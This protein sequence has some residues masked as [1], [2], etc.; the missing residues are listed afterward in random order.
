M[1]LI[2]AE[3]GRMK[4]VDLRGGKREGAGRKSTG[5]TKKVSLTLSDELWNEINEFNGTCA[6]YIRELKNQIA[7]LNKVTNINNEAE[8]SLTEN[9]K[10][11]TSFKKFQEDNELTRKNIEYF[12][13]IYTDNYVREQSEDSKPPKEAIDGAIKSLFNNFFRN[14]D[15]AIAE[16]EIGSRYRSPF[17][18]VW[19]ASIQKLLK[20]EVPRLISNEVKRIQKKKEDAEKKA[21]VEYMNNINKSNFE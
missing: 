3:D 6:D 2:K 14:P 10:K 18:G 4:D 8:S 20:R 19:Y 16:I 1:G 17:N 12:V 11:V 21:H 13:E 5:T 15:T 9:P 7:D